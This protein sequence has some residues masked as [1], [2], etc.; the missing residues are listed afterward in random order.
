ME[1]NKLN[2][3]THQLAHELLMGVDMPVVLQPK[4][5]DDESL[6]ISPV[7]EIIQAESRY[8]EQTTEVSMLCFPHS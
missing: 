3:T 5:Y 8:N 2:K 6:L 4:D 7:I 1:I